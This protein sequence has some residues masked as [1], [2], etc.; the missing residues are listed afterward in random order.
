MDTALSTFSA[1]P[2]KVT[3]RNV[4]VQKVKDEILSGQ[5]HPLQVEAYLKGAEETIKAIRGDRD[6]KEQVIDEL[7]K[8]GKTTDIYGCNFTRSDRRTFNFATCNDSEWDEIT[9]KMEALKEQIKEREAF[10]KT[11]PESGMVN[12]ATGELINPP[13][14]TATPVITV[15]IK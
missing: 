8:Y 4:F 1:L 13:Q 14:Y 10:L 11:I 7:E 9:A 12:P 5:Y 15:K 2:L 6:V 3:D